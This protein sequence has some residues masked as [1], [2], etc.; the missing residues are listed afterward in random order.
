MFRVVINGQANFRRCDNARK[1]RIANIFVS[2]CAQLGLSLLYGERERKK[3]RGK[4]WFF[5]RSRVKPG[6]FLD[7]KKKLMECTKDTSFRTVFFLD[8]FLVRF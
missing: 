1:L 6:L 8:F 3:I 4:R 7:R 2:F 5:Y